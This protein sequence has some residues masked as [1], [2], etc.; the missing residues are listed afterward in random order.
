MSSS[1]QWLAFRDKAMEDGAFIE[2]YITQ[3]YRSWLE[4]DSHAIDGGA[5]LGYHTLP[6]S[7]TLVD[8][9][10]IAVEANE[11]IASKLTARIVNRT[12]IVLEQVA[13][14]EESS[15]EFITFNCSV[16]HPGRSGISRSWDVILPG[17][18]TYEVAVEVPAT[19]IDKLAKKHDLTRLSFIKLDLEG[20]E[21]RSLEGAADVMKQHRPVFVTEHACQSP[22]INDF[23]IEEY[24]DLLALQKYSMLT[25][26]AKLV[27]IS[28][29]FPFW[30][31]FLVPNEKVERAT[32]L[33]ESIYQNSK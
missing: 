15:R 26:S 28:S 3:F 1:E 33:L 17:S 21:F 20:G 12:N 22:E 11:A 30:Y 18:V 13:L 32:T 2:Q 8:G 14:Q 27:T 16:N 7:D 4:R 10:V 23:S 5:H 19:T 6:L 29:P 25:P 9:K 31:V 24:F